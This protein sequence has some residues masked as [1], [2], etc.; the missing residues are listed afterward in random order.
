MEEIVLE[1]IPETYKTRRNVSK[2]EFHSY[3]ID[4]NEQDA[5]DSH[6]H[7]VHLFKKFIEL[8][9]LFLDYQLFGKTLMA[10]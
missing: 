3:L 10:L 4:E 8:A 9:L 1:Y 7:M 6:Y 5:R 2:Y